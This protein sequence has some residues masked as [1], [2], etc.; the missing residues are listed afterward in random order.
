MSIYQIMA[1]CDCPCRPHCTAVGMCSAGEGREITAGTMVELKQKL[2]R[3]MGWPDRRTW[4]AHERRQAAQ[5]W[6]IRANPRV[7]RFVARIRR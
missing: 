6:D 5:V 1:E 3:A 4:T 7:N 2:R